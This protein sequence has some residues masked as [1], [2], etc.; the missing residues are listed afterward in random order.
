MAA[1]TVVVKSVEVGIAKYK[2]GKHVPQQRIY[3][4]Q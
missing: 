2:H 4:Q 3:K 1:E